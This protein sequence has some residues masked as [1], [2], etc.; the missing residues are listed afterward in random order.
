MFPRKHNFLETNTTNH[1]H[2]MQKHGSL[3]HTTPS[4]AYLKLLLHYIKLL[5]KYPKMK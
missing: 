1:K 5:I 2:S 3:V 4:S